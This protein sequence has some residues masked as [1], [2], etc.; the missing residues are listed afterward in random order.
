MKP[1]PRKKREPKT[2][3][4]ATSAG[5]TAA[6]D[7]EASE[8]VVK[9]EP[10]AADEPSAISALP[11][12]MPASRQP[13]VGKVEPNESETQD[14]VARIQHQYRLPAYRQPSRA[15][16][17]AL[18]IAFISHFVQQNNNSRKYT[19]EVPWITQLPNL[20]GATTNPAVR[21]S[22]RAASMAFYAVVHR[23]TTV[24]VDSYRWYIVSL[25]CQR[26]SLARL[27]NGKIPNT[28]EIL[29]PIILSIYETYAGTTTTSIWPHLAAAAKFLELRGPDNCNGVTSTLFKIMRVSDV[30]VQL[31]SFHSS[32]TSPGTQSHR[33]Q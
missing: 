15:V 3:P 7:D 31:L 33:V 24:L 8:V 10:D 25:N 13:A 12:A 28:E 11:P 23:D 18:D 4:G 30:R 16:P 32:L 19:P 26:R 1:R 9:R 2:S 14:A 29:V 22:I 6:A 20:H 21:L 17:D 5:T 27:P